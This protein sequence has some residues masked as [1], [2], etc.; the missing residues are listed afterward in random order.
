MKPTPPYI[1]LKFLRWFC[2]ADYLDEVEGDLI[3]IFESQYGKSPAAARRK[4]MWTVL[5][6]FR[7]EFIKTFNTSPR[8]NSFSMLLNYLK[9]SWRNLTNN[10]LYSSI[11]VGG[12][13]AGIAACILI[14][15]FIHK[16][17]GYDKHYREQDR[18]FR[19]PRPS[20]CSNL[21]AVTH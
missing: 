18:I 21:T 7:P 10:R 14:A 12:F 15:L 13:S 6:H 8:L 3:E 4:F 2:R 17:L 9:V 20:S 5:R 16:E 19:I 1:A 11:K